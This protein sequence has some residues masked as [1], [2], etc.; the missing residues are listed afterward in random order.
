MVWGNVEWR[1]AVLMS[2]GA[3]DIAVVVSS[4]SLVTNVLHSILQE[5][6]R[7]RAGSSTSS[8]WVK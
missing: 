6:S 4:Y 8:P 2:G 3:T 1:D 5:V 7:L